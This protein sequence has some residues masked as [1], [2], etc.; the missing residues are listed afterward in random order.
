MRHGMAFA[1]VL[2]ET[3]KGYGAGEPS[4][5]GQGGFRFAT[6]PGVFAFDPAFTSTTIPYAAVRQ[7]SGRERARAGAPLAAL[8][9][10]AR[11]VRPSSSRARTS[12]LSQSAGDPV[13]AR[14]CRD[15]GSRRASRKAARASA[16]TASPLSFRWDSSGKY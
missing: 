4:S 9:A 2:D 7:A 11:R 12:R 6:S 14:M 1:E 5:A 10:A 3:L 13:V 16:T 15:Y 8:R